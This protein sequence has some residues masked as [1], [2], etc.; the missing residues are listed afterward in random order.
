[1]T[2]PSTM[3]QLRR[4]A[5]VQCYPNM[6]YYYRRSFTFCNVTECLF[7]IVN[8]PCETK[9]IAEAYA[10][11]SVTDRPSIISYLRYQYATGKLF[12]FTF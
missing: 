1:M 2:Q 12:V 11:V 3:I 7:D 6:T 4:E 10:R 5:T 9:N 8:D